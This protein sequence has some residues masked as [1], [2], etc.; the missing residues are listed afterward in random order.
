MEER[1]PDASTP[2]AR[3]VGLHPNT[4]PPDGLDCQEKEELI[5]KRPYIVYTTYKGSRCQVKAMPFPQA[6]DI[7]VVQ[8]KLAN[9]CARCRWAA[10]AAKSPAQARRLAHVSC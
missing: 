9:I 3:H 8:R 2:G 1:G 5:M 7:R 4:R 10:V 6:R